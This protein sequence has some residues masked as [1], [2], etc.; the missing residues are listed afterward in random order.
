MKSLL[1]IVVIAVL[2]GLAYRFIPGVERS[3]N[4]GVKDLKENE[5][6]ENWEFYYDQEIGK[7]ASKLAGFEQQRMETV[8][9]ALR[10]ERDIE[11]MNG[12]VAEA[13]SLVQEAAAA[14]RAAKD[15]V[16]LEEIGSIR[17]TLLGQEKSIPQATEQLRV[18]IGERNRIQAEAA[19]LEETLNRAKDARTKELAVFEKARVQIDALKREKNFMRSQMKISEIEQR[20]L[21]L[22]RIGDMWA[23]SD[24][25]SELA[26]VRTLIDDKLLHDEARLELARQENQ[27]DQQ[28]GLQEAFDEREKLGSSAEVEAEL[29][30]L[31][32]G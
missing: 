32:G 18:W 17:I 2:G 29:A 10:L 23:S 30:E 31:L 20:M 6:L 8:S 7:L 12:Q 27:I 24:S 3:V 15:G 11:E 22:E 16:A 9:Q 1:I 4:A 13:E 25:P 14:I 26:N 19:Q 5:V 21:D 28:M